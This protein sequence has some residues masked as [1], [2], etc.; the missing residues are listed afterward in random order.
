MRPLSPPGMFTAWREPSS[1]GGGAPWAASLWYD[2]PCCPPFRSRCGAAPRAR[3]SGGREATM[4]QSHPA[5]FDEVLEAVESLP[6]DQQDGL[7][8]IVRRRQ[9]ERRR[10]ALAL[11]TQEARQELAQ[12][13]CAEG[14]RMSC[15]ASSD[16]EAARWSNTFRRAL[17]RT[18]RR[19]ELRADIESTLRLLQQDPFAA[20]PARAVDRRTRA[21]RSSL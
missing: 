7:I 1:P 6:D 18:R 5:R 14:Q 12:G 17:R 4:T 9:I 19:P 2:S 15:S 3:R 10:E 11:S 13:L 21:Y 8:D 16:R 20:Q